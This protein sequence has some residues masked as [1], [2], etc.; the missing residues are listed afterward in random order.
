M[1]ALAGP[2]WLG[3]G[4]TCWGCREAPRRRGTFTP[5]R[6]GAWSKPG[7]SDAPLLFLATPL[8]DGRVHQAY[9]SGVIEL[10]HALPGRLIVGKFSGR[11][12][13]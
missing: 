13:Q 1:R 11:S 9:M 4:F 8:H 3:F 2:R 6:P 12:C 7:M 10:A 5:E